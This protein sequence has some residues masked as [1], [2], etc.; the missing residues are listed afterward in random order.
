M[1]SINVPALLDRAVLVDDPRQ[2]AM[3]LELQET[4]RAADAYM[5]AARNPN[6]KRNY[7]ADWRHFEA[8]CARHGYET[9]PA[10]PQTV[11]YYLSWMAAFKSPKTGEPLK[12]K[13]IARR[14]VTLGIVHRLAGFPQPADDPT[15]RQVWRGIRQTHGTASTPKAALMLEQLRAIVPPLR[16]DDDGNPSNSPHELRERALLLV[17]WATALRRSNIA[18]VLIEDA[19]I[20]EVLGLRLR[21]RFSKT[22]Q[23]GENE[24]V[25][26]RWGEH[27]DT[28]PVRALQMWLAY[29]RDVHDI[30]QGPI[31]RKIDRW[32]KPRDKALSAEWVARFIKEACARAGLDPRLFSGHSM[33]RGFVTTAVVAGKSDAAIMRQTKHKSLATLAAYKDE[34]KLYTDNPTEGLGL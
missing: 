9:L 17:N 32:G 7:L 3:N 34:A 11:R 27:A 22:N 19:K 14:L 28:C 4:Q 2:V 21:I 5:A 10:T 25:T 1:T 6:T 33:R 30:R 26:V 16:T 23:L 12:A 20:E 13:T 31:F 24:F 29:L 15:V 18:T 8:Y